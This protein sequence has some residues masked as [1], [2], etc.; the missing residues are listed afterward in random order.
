MNAC[1]DAKPA[2]TLA[3]NRPREPNGRLWQGGYEDYGRHHG[4]DL[5]ALARHV[6]AKP[7]GAGL[8]YTAQGII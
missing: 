1:T 2:S 7:L 8:I 4:H 6:L 5:T 3:I